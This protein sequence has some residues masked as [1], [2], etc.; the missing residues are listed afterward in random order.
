[1]LKH[2]YVIIVSSVRKN[3]PNAVILKL[4]ETVIQH[5]GTFPYS[6]DFLHTLIYHILIFVIEIDACQCSLKKRTVW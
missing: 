3:K 2:L 6:S 4:L 1:M 5:T